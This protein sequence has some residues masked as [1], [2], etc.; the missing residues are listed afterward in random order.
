M[1]D[2]GRWFRGT[3]YQY[4]ATFRHFM[5]RL[6][7]AV[8]GNAVRRYRKQLRVI[9]V[10]EK[11]L[12]GRWHYHAAIEPPFHISL[13]DFEKLVHECWRKTHWG[14]D[15]VL[16]R[17]NADQGWIIYMLKPRQKSEFETWSDCIDWDT[18]HNPIADA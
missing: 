12:H 11:G 9:A 8:Y 17:D 7:G 15:R 16:V 10:L 4:R 5:K 13:E 1:A 2:D 3:E 18:L 6:N 14:Y